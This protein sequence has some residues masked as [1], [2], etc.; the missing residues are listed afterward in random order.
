MIFGKGG[1]NTATPNFATGPPI[2]LIFN[3]YALSV[4]QMIK[5]DDKSMPSE[6]FSLKMP[7]IR[8]KKKSCERKI[9]ITNSDLRPF[10]CRRFRQ[11]LYKC[12]FS[13]FFA[14]TFYLIVLN[15][16]EYTVLFMIHAR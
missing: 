10:F 15:M 14:A 8:L 4:S 7:L 16:K 13:I 11:L 12:F 6:E 9:K 2:A 3:K 5:W 1:R